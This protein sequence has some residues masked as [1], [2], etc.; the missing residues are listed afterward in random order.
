MDFNNA[1]FGMDGRLSKSHP[2]PM[3]PGYS[4]GHILPQPPP[5]GQ[6]VIGQ[7]TAVQYAQP[8][9]AHCTPQSTPAQYSSQIYG[10]PR[11]A[12]CT[13]QPCVQPRPAHYAPQIDVQPGSAHCMTQPFVQPR[14]AD[15]MPQRVSAPA[16][17]SSTP[18]TKLLYTNDIPAPFSD[19]RLD[20]RAQ[21]SFPNAHVNQHPSQTPS[22]SQQTNQSADSMY[23]AASN[24]VLKSFKP[25][26]VPTPKGQAMYDRQRPVSHPVPGA[27]F[28]GGSPQF[29]TSQGQVHHDMNSS[30]FSKPSYSFEKFAPTR[31][32][33]PHSNGFNNSNFSRMSSS[34]SNQQS[35]MYPAHQRRPSSL[36]SQGSINSGLQSNQVMGNQMRHSLNQASTAPQGVNANVAYYR[37][38]GSAPGLKDN[39]FM[40]GLRQGFPPVS[41]SVPPQNYASAGQTSGHPSSQHVL[42]NDTLGMN[43]KENLTKRSIFENSRFNPRQPYQQRT[44]AQHPAASFPH[45]QN[46]RPSGVC[47]PSPM[48]PCHAIRDQERLLV[49]KE[50]VIKLATLFKADPVSFPKCGISVS[51][52]QNLCQKVGIEFPVISNPSFQE[53]LSTE[54]PC[55]EPL[56]SLSKDDAALIQ[57]AFAIPQS[58]EPKEAGSKWYAQPSLGKPVIEETE[59]TSRN[60]SPHSIADIMKDTDTNKSPMVSTQCKYTYTMSLPTSTISSSSLVNSTTSTSS[61]SPFTESSMSSLPSETSISVSTDSD[62]GDINH[63]NRDTINTSAN[64]FQPINDIELESHDGD[65]SVIDQSSSLIDP[66]SILDLNKKKVIDELVLDSQY[67]SQDMNDD[68]DIRSYLPSPELPPDFIHPVAILNELPQSVNELI[69]DTSEPE[70]NISETIQSV[71]VPTQNISE[72]N[73]N[74]MDCESMVDV[75]T[76]PVDTGLPLLSANSAVQTADEVNNAT[77]DVIMSPTRDIEHNLPVPMSANRSGEKRKHESVD[78]ENSPSVLAPPVKV[79]RGNGRGRVKGRGRGSRNGVVKNGVGT[80]KSSRGRGRGRGR[81]W[82][83]KCFTDMKMRCTI[84]PKKPLHTV[85]KGRGRGRG[86]GRGHGRKLHTEQDKMNIDESDATI[87]KLDNDVIQKPDDLKAY[88]DTIDSDELNRKVVPL[89]TVKAMMDQWKMNGATRPDSGNKSDT[90]DTIDI[91]SITDHAETD[92]EETL[93]AEESPACADIENVR[94]ELDNQLKDESDIVRK[95]D[96]IKCDK[97]DEKLSDEK[98]PTQ[99]DSN[100]ED[101]KNKTLS[102]EDSDM[103]VNDNVN[104]NYSNPPEL[105]GSSSVKVKGKAPKCQGLNR[106]I[107]NVTAHTYA[108]ND[109]HRI[110]WVRFHGKIV[111]RLIT[112]D[113]NFFILTE[114]LRRCFRIKEPNKRKK[115]KKIKN[116]KK[117]RLNIPDIN[118]EQVFFYYVVQSLQSRDV[119]RAVPDNFE[120]ISEKNACRLFHYV[121]ERKYCKDG[122]ITPY[123]KTVPS[124]VQFDGPVCDLDKN[125]KNPDYSNVVRNVNNN[126]KDRNVFDMIQGEMGFNQNEVIDLCSEDSDGYATDVTCPYVDGEPYK[127]VRNKILN[128]KAYTVDDTDTELTDRCDIRNATAGQKIDCVKEMIENKGAEKS[129]SVPIA[130]SGESDSSLNNSN[131]CDTKKVDI[132]E[133]ISSETC[134]R[135]VDGTERVTSKTCNE[136][137]NTTES[138]CGE[139][140]KEKSGAVESVSIETGHKTPI[141]NNL[142]SETYFK[143]DLKISPEKLHKI[144]KQLSITL[145]T[146]KDYVRTDNLVQ[147]NNNSNVENIRQCSPVSGDLNLDK[148]ADDSRQSAI[149]K[150]DYWTVNATLGEDILDGGSNSS[151][152]V[153]TNVIDKHIAIPDNSNNADEHV[154]KEINID[155]DKMEYNSD[156]TTD[157]VQIDDWTFPGPP[158]SYPEYGSQK[159]LEADQTLQKIIEEGNNAKTDDEVSSVL[160]KVL[161]ISKPLEKWSYT[162]FDSYESILLLEAERLKS[163]E[164]LAD[165]PDTVDMDLGIGI[166]SN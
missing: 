4:T 161:C 87:T 41:T 53:Y 7:Q 14:P 159:L 124:K 115:Y 126:L 78:D 111:T 97:T 77:N 48:R 165:M 139:T 85:G 26:T 52:L 84:T 58:N 65:I 23:P 82:A 17:D 144:R 18:S 8:R 151:C 64:L 108:L 69:R 1:S 9:P 105:S 55:S 156:N 57:S 68:I 24:N 90:G 6:P 98:K 131:K 38:T 142:C 154:D 133:N 36:M 96:V 50:K 76:E 32:V 15:V 22:P 89:S 91:R 43:W 21:S 31:N 83:V 39:M 134:K 140:G 146:E 125:G 25:I 10:Q 40:H 128:E 107:K 95:K 33:A 44:E 16:Y 72:P 29:D 12:H 13:P 60:Y 99:I 155:K 27:N 143:K 100:A 67:S 59:Q 42:Q 74:T 135:K 62:I 73:K 45:G 150:N 56:N 37:P 106:V 49:F 19:S 121:C 132:V 114:I 51:A 103:E 92:S 164:R 153:D 145:D 66:V 70:Q 20:H 112:P 123:Y 152:K 46:I 75:K 122:C 113:G 88:I 61:R 129:L 34:V 116:T 127:D 148:V 117:E 101:N 54:S 2:Q 102:G 28:T 149:D 138:V 147:C 157:D 104:N 5:Y 35:N 63:T 47:Q 80:G 81:L 160:D 11:P 118:M 110:T 3:Y 158:K 136:K 86:R 30:H 109:T 94:T 130:D 119:I 120:I 163:L 162:L 141:I 93:T 137:P 166:E 79:A 71:G